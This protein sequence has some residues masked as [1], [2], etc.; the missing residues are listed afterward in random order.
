MVTVY[1]FTIVHMYIRRVGH[2]NKVHCE[3]LAMYAI[4][5]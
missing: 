1:Y 4:K 2:I 3:Y 5:D